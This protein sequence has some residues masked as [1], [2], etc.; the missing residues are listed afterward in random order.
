VPEQPILPAFEFQSRTRFFTL[1][2][3]RE[4]LSPG[5]FEWRGQVQN[6]RGGEVRYFHDWPML[7]VC[8][9]DLFDGDPGA[10]R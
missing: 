5:C 9:Q 4:E 6:V 8:L 3:W 2:V 7:I 1:R 10:D